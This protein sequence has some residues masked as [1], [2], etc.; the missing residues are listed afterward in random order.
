MITG[1]HICLDTS[2]VQGSLPC[3]LANPPG[4]ILS[5]QDEFQIHA[6]TRRPWLMC[7]HVLWLVMFC[8]WSLEGGLKRAMQ[9][10]LPSVWT[11][12][13]QNSSLKCYHTA[14]AQQPRLCSFAGCKYLFRKTLHILLKLWSWKRIMGMYGTKRMIAFANT[15]E[16][17][18]AFFV[19]TEWGGQGVITHSCLKLRTH[20]P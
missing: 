17:M 15:S 4:A 7:I 9:G 3:F 14:Q 1:H 12:A 5:C 19:V 2:L 11:L 10:L 20:F 8:R 13:S 16:M 18:G 6:R